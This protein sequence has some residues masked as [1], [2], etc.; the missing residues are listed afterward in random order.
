MTFICAVSFAFAQDSTMMKSKSGIPILPEA[1]EWALGFDATTFIKYFGNLFHASD[2]S[3]SATPFFTANSPALTIY[4][5]KC[6]AADKFYRAKLRLG[7]GNDKFNY[8]VPDKA[9]SKD[10]TNFNETYGADERTYTHTNINLSLGK[11]FRRGKGRVQ[12][13]YG[14]EAFIEFGNSTVTNKFHNVLDSTMQKNSADITEFTAEVPANDSYGPLIDAE[15]RRITEV[16]YGSVFGIGVRG[17]AGVEYFFM[18]K[19]SIGAEF[20]WG[21][22]IASHGATETTTEYYENTPPTNSSSVPYGPRSEI[23]GNPGKNSS[24]AIDTDNAYGALNLFFYF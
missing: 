23:H 13:V 18:A 24:F 15:G 4:G 16:N 8:E 11:E 1:G 10:S 17:F 20:G 7:Y 9:T 12:G 22:G 19:A 3:G 14:Y 6:I 5:K 21:I 2:S